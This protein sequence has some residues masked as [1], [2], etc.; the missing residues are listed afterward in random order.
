VITYYALVGQR[1]MYEYGTTHEQLAEIAVACRK[2]ATL[3]P[4]AVMGPMGEITVEDV[5]NSRPI[6]TPLHLLDCS[7]WTD[8]GAA[9]LMTSAERAKDA[10]KPPVYILGLGHSATSYYTGDLARPRPNLGLSLTNTVGKIAGDDAFSEAGVTRDEIDFVQL[11]DNF[12]ISAL[13]QFE[14]LGFCKKGEGGPFVQGGRVQLGGDLPLNTH[15]GHLSCTFT[16]AGYVHWVEGVRQLRG[17][18]DARQV[19]N[20]KIGLVSTWA[21]TIATYGGVGILARD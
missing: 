13:V 7:V 21:S 10:P 17:E 19:K 12:T 1:H 6:T 15:G 3:N 4:E 20:A 18:G 11:Y 16:P 5:V 2:H 9:L 8:G 14:D